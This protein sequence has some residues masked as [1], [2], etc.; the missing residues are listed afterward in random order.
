MENRPYH[1]QSPSLGEQVNPP[2]NDRARRLGP[3]WDL[4]S[5]DLA[6]VSNHRDRNEVLGNF[7]NLVKMPLKLVK[8]WLR[9]K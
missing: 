5:M 9:S 8:S 4:D 7:L 1:V 3:D 6:W 2:T